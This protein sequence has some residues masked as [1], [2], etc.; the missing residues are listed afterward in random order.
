MLNE[1]FI[2]LRLYEVVGPSA[3]SS[4]RRRFS[5]L[6][7]LTLSA[8]TK[9][10]PSFLT[11]GAKPG[12]AKDVS[13]SSAARRGIGK[14]RLVSALEETLAGEVDVSWRY[15][16][17]ALHRDSSLHPVIA[18]WK[19]EAG[20]SPRLLRQ[21]SS[22]KARSAPCFRELARADF[23]LIAAMLSVPLGEGY[24]CVEL[25]PRECKYKMF[26]VRLS[27]LTSVSCN[28]PVLMLV[29]DAQWADASSIELFD[30]VVDCIQELQLLVI[31]TYRPEFT[32]PWIEARRRR[33]DR[34]RTTGQGTVR[35]PR[36]ASE[37]SSVH[38]PRATRKDYSAS[39]RHPIVHRVPHQRGP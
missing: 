11:R 37:R 12:A 36:G 4:A 30:R 15:F 34:A 20:F 24:P 28:A 2:P 39:R 32:P 38:R 16:C 35:R 5:P 29:E 33:S 21:V 3:H 22:G 26:E 25:S 18:R 7:N 8:A 19:Q 9:S 13:S 31:V 10:L 17:S 6:E 14:S 23:A 27:R 1:D